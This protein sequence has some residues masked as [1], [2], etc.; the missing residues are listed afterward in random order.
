[1]LQEELDENQCLLMVSVILFS[2]ESLPDFIQ[3]D[4]MVYTVKKKKKKA[5]EMRVFLHEKCV[6]FTKAVT[7][8]VESSL[9][10]HRVFEYSCSIQ[11]SGRLI[12]RMMYDVLQ[13]V[14]TLLKSETVEKGK[15]A[16]K[17]G[18]AENKAGPDREYI[19]QVS[20]KRSSKLCLRHF[21][22]SLSIRVLK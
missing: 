11:V 10:N 12:V 1:M 7:S 5:E 22:I 13:Q 21:L 14:N 20:T 6:I 8:T 19:L 17:F 3:D 18:L 2:H 9:S 15:H 16:E 4:F